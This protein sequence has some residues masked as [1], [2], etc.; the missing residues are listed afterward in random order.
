MDNWSA[1]DVYEWTIRIGLPSSM[2]KNFLGEL[3]IFQNSLCSWD[4]PLGIISISLSLFRFLDENV[5]KLGTSSILSRPRPR[6]ALFLNSLIPL[7]NMWDITWENGNS[8][9]LFSRLFQTFTGTNELKLLKRSSQ[10]DD[11]M[12][13]RPFLIEV[14]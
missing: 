11:Q 13:W 9:F 4:Y 6:Q 2:A 3:I 5:L 8:K 14:E 10:W 7:T 12:G 1:Q